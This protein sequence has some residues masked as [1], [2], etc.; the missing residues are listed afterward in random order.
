MA[1]YIKKRE[2]DGRGTKSKETCVVECSTQIFDILT[3]IVESAGNIE[4]PLFERGGPVKI[5]EGEE[6]KFRGVD[7]L[8]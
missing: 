3:D 2:K 4:K 7:I 8:D 1:T 5:Q 6:T